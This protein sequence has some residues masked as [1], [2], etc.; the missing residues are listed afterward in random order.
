MSSLVSIC[1]GSYLCM[2]GAVLTRLASRCVRK[3]NTSDNWLANGTPC[4]DFDDNDE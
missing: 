1:A 2:K 4:P 3:D